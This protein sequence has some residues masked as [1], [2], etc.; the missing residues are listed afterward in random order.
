MRATRQ[1]S[2]VTSTSVSQAR[3]APADAPGS[4]TTSVGQSS[5]AVSRSWTKPITGR[6]PTPKPA[7]NPATALGVAVGA[8]SKVSK[9]KEVEVFA[10]RDHRGDNERDNSEDEHAGDRGDGHD[11][12]KHDG[13]THKRSGHCDAAYGE[14]ESPADKEGHS[15][16]GV[17]YSVPREANRRRGEVA[18][19]ALMARPRDDVYSGNTDTPSLQ[20]PPD[21][22]PNLWEGHRRQHLPSVAVGN[23]QGGVIPAS[24]LPTLRPPNV[25]PVEYGGEQRTATVVAVGP[26]A[27]TLG[28]DPRRAMARALWMGPTGPKSASGSPAAEHASRATQGTT[29]RPCVR[30]RS[31]NAPSLVVAITL[32]RRPESRTIGPLSVAVT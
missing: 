14:H 26:G 1:V 21:S 28:S 30:D 27:G 25:L 8:V 12:E 9:I 6:L 5:S 20:Q 24:M 31:N 17:G 11:D 10:N 7:D 19:D 23:G 2:W 4:S 32:S 13:P 18:A 3:N 29:K 15:R 22:D 16:R